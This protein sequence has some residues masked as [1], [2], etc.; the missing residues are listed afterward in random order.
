MS[1]LVSDTA[2]ERLGRDTHSTLYHGTP[3]DHS[4]RKEKKRKNMES[5]RTVRFLCNGAAKRYDG[6]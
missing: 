5:K 2:I 1:N 3:P 6:V 4:L